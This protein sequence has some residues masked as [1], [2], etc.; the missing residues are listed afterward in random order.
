MSNIPNQSADQAQLDAPSPPVDTSEETAFLNL[1]IQGD[2]QGAMDALSVMHIQKV[3]ALIF[4]FKNGKEMI[5]QVIFQRTSNG[6]P[7]YVD[8][9][10]PMVVSTEADSGPNR[11]VPWGGDGRFAGRGAGQY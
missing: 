7:D 5:S 2:D 1:L 6:G 3:R 9:P 10:M 11:D 4:A 8:Q